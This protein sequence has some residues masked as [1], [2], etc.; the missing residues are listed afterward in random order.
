VG[1]IG[2]PIKHIELEPLEVPVEVPVPEK[3]PEKVGAEWRTTT[4][5]TAVGGTRARGSLS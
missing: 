4:T 3:E 1:N 5:S 2:E